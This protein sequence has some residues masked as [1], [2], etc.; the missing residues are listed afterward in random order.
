MFYLVLIYLK[1]LP[2]NV[3]SIPHSSNMT[4]L[5]KT[6]WMILSLPGKQYLISI[7]S[8]P[9]LESPML[10]Q[11]NSIVKLYY[12]FSKHSSL[13]FRIFLWFTV[14]WKGQMGT[15]IV[16]NIGMVSVSQIISHID[17]KI[18]VIF[19]WQISFNGL[20]PLFLSTFNWSHSSGSSYL[21]DLDYSCNLQI[22]EV[23][24]NKTDYIS[25]L[26]TWHWTQI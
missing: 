22:T 26:L 6:N 8:L 12:Y 21:I 24:I 25:C 17:W 9:L 1:I 18:Q 23:C 7:I 13:F 5:N 14:H 10:K 2:T 19:L 11:Q 4:S 15:F 20:C 16:N 3:S